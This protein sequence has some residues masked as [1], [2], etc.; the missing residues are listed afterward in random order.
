[1]RDVA[2]DRSGTSRRRL[3]VALV[4]GALAVLGVVLGLTT[5]A[6]WLSVGVIGMFVSIIAFGPIV[7]VPI[8]N[9]LTRPL[10][11]IRGVTGQVAGRN[12]SRS[13]ERTALTAAALGIGLA[14][15]VAVST[16]A[17]SLQDSLRATFA[18]SFVGQIA[19]TPEQANGG[20]LPVSLAA[21]LDK[22]PKSATRSVSAVGD[23]RCRLASATRR[24][25]R[26]DSF[27]TP[28]ARRR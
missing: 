25:A 13:P 24:R 5:S 2:I 7:V 26:S 22:L 21:D 19:V 10:R 20:F 15:L 6:L 8:S 1:M 9:F 18:K 28:R 14:L 27:S 11:A 3:V 17:S 23:S 16:L 12:A 4:S